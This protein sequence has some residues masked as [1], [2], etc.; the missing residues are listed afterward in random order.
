[1][2]AFSIVAGHFLLILMI[3]GSVAAGVSYQ[4]TDALW[5]E[6]RD[7]FASGDRLGIAGLI[8]S[9]EGDAGTVSRY[10]E[11]ERA[12]YWEAHDLA[13]EVFVAQQGIA[14][15]LARA[16]I[17]SE[18]DP[19]VSRQLKAAASRIAFNLASSTWPGWDEEG[20]RVTAD[21]RELGAA[22]AAMALEISGE[23][24]AGAAALANGNWMVGAH[25][26]AAGEPDQ[27]IESFRR[28]ALYGRA[29]KDRGTELVSEGFIAITEVTAGRNLEDARRRLADIRQTVD[30]ELE[31]PG[32][33]TSQFDTAWR[34]FVD[35]KESG[36]R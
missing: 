32:F 11:V 34:V 26:L 27:A 21:E 18:D 4:D 19:V 24:D 15:C 17:L 10:F 2:R 7:A 31:D 3:A 35:R 23:L 16:T 20:I 28:A 30:E 12:L 9:P 25:H 5:V 14:F 6:V 13:A 8:A 29:A 1:M 22:A 33:W 36:V